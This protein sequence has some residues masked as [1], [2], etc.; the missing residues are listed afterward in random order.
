[1][2]EPD[3]P[4]PPALVEAGVAALRAGA[5]RYTPRLGYATLRQAICAELAASG[6]PATPDDVV[7]TGG[8]TPAVAIALGAACRP[9]DA[10]LVPD[11]GW[12]NYE[13]FA[14]R[15][16]LTTRRYRQDPAP[17]VAFDLEEIEALI[18]GETRMI[19]ITSPSNPTG[20]VADAELVGGLVALAERRDLLICS[21]EAYERIAFGRAPVSPGALGGAARTFSCHTLSKTYAMTGW[22]VGWVVVPPAFRGPALEMQ[23]AICG[24]ASAMG[25]RAAEAALASE[26]PEVQAAIASYRRRR[27]L[28]VAALAGTRLLAAPPEGAFYLWLDVGATG[29]SGQ[30]FADRLAAEHDVLVSAGEVYSVLQPG[31]VRISFAT[32]EAQLLDGLG[33]LVALHD[34]LAR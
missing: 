12:P 20:G 27:D 30:E 32:A 26:P 17:G 5:T 6:Y 23:V 4:T 1:V 28:A 8:G 15:F 31:H 24:C 14:G 3:G 11:P 25:Q 22:R 33:R 16:G 34:E 29:L 9:G 18:D 13:I 10:I 19:V 21:D 2:G 7:V